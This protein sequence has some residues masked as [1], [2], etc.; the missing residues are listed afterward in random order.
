MRA[1]E[2]RVE[3]SLP[4]ADRGVDG[5]AIRLVE[6]WE[7]PILTTIVVCMLATVW[8]VIAVSFVVGLAVKASTRAVGTVF[9]AV[10]FAAIMAD[11]AVP[12]SQEPL[13]ATAQTCAVTFA[14]SLVAFFA[15]FVFL[16]LLRGR[17]G[18]KRRA[19]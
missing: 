6:G 11:S 7:S 15:G 3:G 14:G 5:P 2:A 4:K 9:A 1:Q 17:R 18:R 16:G 10:W 12:E 19:A 13:M 8:L